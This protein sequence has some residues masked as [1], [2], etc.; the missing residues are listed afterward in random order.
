VSFRLSRR[1]VDIPLRL[2]NDNTVY[3]DA[4][5]GKGPQP[6][7]ELLPSETAGLHVPVC[8]RNESEANMPSAGPPEFNMEALAMLEALGFPTV[9]CQRA[10]LATGN[11]DVNAAMEWL[12][13]HMDDPGD[14][15]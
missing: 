1:G 4:Y 6:G 12:F 5:L 3:L 11:A 15:F 14:H 9:R 7:E 2:P 8:S 10:L 13:V